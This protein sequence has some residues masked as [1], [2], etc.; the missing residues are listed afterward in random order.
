MC[1]ANVQLQSKRCRFQLIPIN[2]S[3]KNKNDLTVPRAEQP[4][5]Y[6]KKI[7]LLC[8]VE[9]WDVVPNHLV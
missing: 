4:V 2:F 9:K 6:N 1:K 8:C 7:P 3:I 5:S